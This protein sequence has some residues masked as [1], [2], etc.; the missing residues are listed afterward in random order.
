MGKDFFLYSITL[1]PQEDSPEV[2]AKY[3]ESLG[4]GPGWLFLTGKYEHLEELRYQ[5][6]AYDL[7]P[8]I[9]ADKEQHT[10]LVTFG[11]DRSN[12]WA[13]LPALMDADGLARSI[14]RITR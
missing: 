7:D 2:L 4:A 5:L 12:R 10:G 6:G 9:D 3:A 11:N 14:R 8:I 1:R 13:A